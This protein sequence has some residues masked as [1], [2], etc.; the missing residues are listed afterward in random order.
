MSSEQ[1]V[2][3]KAAEKAERDWEV[4]YWRDKETVKRDRARAKVATLAHR[5][6]ELEGQRTLR[7]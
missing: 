1:P 5:L 3:G 2:E 6:S 7:L 4:N